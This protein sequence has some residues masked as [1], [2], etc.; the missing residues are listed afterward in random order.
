MRSPV[1][2]RDDAEAVVRAWQAHESARGGRDVVDYD[3]A[4][5]PPGR[6]P[7]AAL[8]RLDVLGRLTALR[9]AAL[10]AGD[11]ALAAA[12]DAHV[13]YL[14]HVLGE[15][16]PL[17]EYLRRTQGCEPRV[18]DDAHTSAV[19]ETARA[20]LAG[21]GVGWGPRAMSDLDAADTPLDLTEARDRVEAVA[22][23]AEPRVRELAGTDAPYEVSTEVVDV[24][25]Y[26][27]YWLD[28]AG[29]RV[30]LR[31]NLRHARFSETRL[32]QFALHELLGHALQSASYARRA[33]TSD[34]PW[35]RLL[36][37][38]LPYQVC[39]EGLAT[40]LPLFVAPDDAALVAR[41]RVDHHV[42]LVRGRIHTDVAA[43]VPLAE[44][45][46]R[47]IARVPW[48]GTARV[49]DELADRGGD[50]ML[51]SYLWSYCAG[52]DWFAGLADRADAATI[53]RVFHAAYRD[54]LTPADLRALW[55]DGEL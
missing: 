6:R 12:L 39:L 22:R 15:R 20:A 55:P 30:R 51:R 8:D 36:S 50:P 17:A 35:L 5:P 52:T 14:G 7:P 19:E 32:R 31:F 24:D 18:W 49:A 40:T 44:I 43:G 21:L 3:C 26:W 9:D 41:V 33:A 27:A 29:S 46:R 42:Q 45:A 23:G 13:A 10:A 4:P 25:D 38:N 37:V 34:V 53:R 47:A 48:W 28:G 11:G 16:P 2:L 1:S 54:P